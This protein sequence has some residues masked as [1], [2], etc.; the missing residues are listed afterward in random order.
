MQVELII[1]SNSYR[2]QFNQIKNV[3]GVSQ[4]YYADFY[5]SSC[6]F[7]Y[8]YYFQKNNLNWY[9]KSWNT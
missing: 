2:V 3:D 4:E 5:V 8:S 9:Q 7:K 1:L 6:L